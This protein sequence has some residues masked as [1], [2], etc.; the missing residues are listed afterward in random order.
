VV[1]SA[2]WR[3]LSVWDEEWEGR[4]TCLSVVLVLFRH[5]GY[6]WWCAKRK[7]LTKGS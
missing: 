4:R 5:V 2:D 1:S 6:M 7:D 3:A